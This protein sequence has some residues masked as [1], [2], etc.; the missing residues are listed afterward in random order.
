MCSLEVCFEQRHLL[1]GFDPRRGQKFL[2]RLVD[3][4]E[5]KLE[6]AHADVAT[7][8]QYGR[9]FPACP[10]AAHQAQAVG[11]AA[12]WSTRLEPSTEHFPSDMSFGSAN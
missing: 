12:A 1:R 10:A 9:P 4:A 11:L 5:H 3:D 8:M 6:T 7:V 2:G